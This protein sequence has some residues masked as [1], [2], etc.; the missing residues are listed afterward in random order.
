M[1]RYTV[2]HITTYEYAEDV[3]LGHSEA[4]LL[5]R[6]ESHQICHNSRLD[7][8]PRP[9]ALWHRQDYFGNRITFFSLQNAHRHLEVKATSEIELY[10]RGI[11][12]NQDSPAWETV[13]EL[14][15]TGLEGDAL[16]AREMILD[17]TYIHRN[18]DFADYAL[19]SFTPQ[20]PMLDACYDLMNRIYREFEYDP[21]FTS[22]GTPL[23]EVF[24][25][26]RGV[27]Q[28][29]AHFFIAALRSINLPARYMSGY[30][31][32]EPP[33]DKKEKLRGA[34]ASH[35]W[36]SVYIPPTGWV[37][38]DPTNNQIPS[39]QHILLACGRDFQDVS[40]LRGV[41]FGG[42]KHVVHVSVD[43]RRQ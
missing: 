19:L 30:I 41:I 22:V 16:S 39:V 32:N 38:F 3:S 17:S 14:V 2:T 43:V 20:R 31:E 24:R 13:R 37:E 18:Q 5:P 35:A 1:I 29:F 40:P 26:R 6:N 27:C 28:D 9:E 12:A 34:D 4:H 23:P 7:I 8:Q 25:H 11:K 36:I 10:D 33:P 42:G 21:R 15:A